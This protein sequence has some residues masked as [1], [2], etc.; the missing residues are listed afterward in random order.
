MNDRKP[1]KFTV[2]KNPIKPMHK[3]ANFIFFTDEKLFARV[4][5]SNSQNNRVKDG[6]N[7]V[8]KDVDC[9]RLF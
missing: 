6:I 4:R 3:Y 8:K 2:F 1:T 7:K 9:H 5:P